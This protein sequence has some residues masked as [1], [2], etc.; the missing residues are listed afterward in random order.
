[1]WG[2]RMWAFCQNCNTIS[3]LQHLYLI[4]TI[5]PSDLLKAGE[6]RIVKLVAPNAL[7]LLKDNLKH[8]NA[9]NRRQRGGDLTEKA[10]PHGGPKRSLDVVDKR[11]N[12][13]TAIT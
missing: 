7:E 6:F 12:C 11:S 9:R 4:F 3:H 2:L 5:L 8:Q 13:A 10:R 1:M